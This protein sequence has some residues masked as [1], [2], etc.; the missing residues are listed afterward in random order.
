MWLGRKCLEKMKQGMGT[1]CQ[2]WAVCA[3][4][5]KLCTAKSFPNPTDREESIK[6]AFSSFK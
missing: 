6:L 5:R 1:H 2:S 4:K 3:K